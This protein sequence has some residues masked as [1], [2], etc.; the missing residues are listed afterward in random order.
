MVPLSGCPD[1]LPNQQ[2]NQQPHDES[3]EWSE[4]VRSIKPDMRDKIMN[5]GVVAASTDQEAL[6]NC[7]FNLNC[8]QTDSAWLTD[9]SANSEVTSIQKL[10]ILKIGNA[11]DMQKRDKWIDNLSEW[12]RFNLHRFYHGFVDSNVFMTDVISY[13]LSS[14]QIEECTLRDVFANVVRKL[15]D[16][17]ASTTSDHSSTVYT[18]KTGQ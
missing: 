13:A 16:P 11:R 12:I 1:V 3:H 14:E 6:R 2:P 7:S 9:A 8:W 17:A 18:T 4:H 15:I 5:S 10:A